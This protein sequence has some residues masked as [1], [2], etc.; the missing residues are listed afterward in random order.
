M[1]RV[2][3][4]RLNHLLSRRSTKVA[5]LIILL[6]LI[7]TILEITNV[8]NFFKNSSI[9]PVIPVSQAP[10]ASTENS[11]NTPQKTPGTDKSNSSVG[12]QKVDLPLYSPY[13]AFIS[14]HHPNLSGHPAP[15]SESSVCN[16]TPGATCYI[17]FTNGSLTTKLPSRVADSKGSAYWSWDVKTAGLTA[18]NWTVTAVA[19]LNGTVKS[20]QDPMQ[21]TIAK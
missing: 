11:Q 19:S 4:S 18:G 7:A 9:Q 6:L 16:T 5:G 10:P 12:S 1:P 3:K 20:T 13:G 14:N 8:T 17:K 2:R 15:S 21:L